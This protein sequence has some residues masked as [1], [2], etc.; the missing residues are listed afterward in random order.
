MKRQ[1]NTAKTEIED[2]DLPYWSLGEDGNGLVKAI[3]HLRK[4][5]SVENEAVTVQNVSEAAVMS[6]GLATA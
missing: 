1:R 3:Q 4:A 5:Q 6:Y 2:E